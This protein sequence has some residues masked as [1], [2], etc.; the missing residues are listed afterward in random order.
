VCCR[1]VSSVLPVCC[2]YVAGCYV[3]CCVA[4]GVLTVC[5]RCV[6]VCWCVLVCSCE[7]VTLED[8][9]EVED[10][11]GQS[12]NGHLFNLLR[13]VDPRPNTAK[14]LPEHGGIA[15]VREAV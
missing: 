11:C 10:R 9:R 14:F 3:A 12:W 13:C 6:G 4:A 8:A 7:R 1:C 2:R 5:C 15:H